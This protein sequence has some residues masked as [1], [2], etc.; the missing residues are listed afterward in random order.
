MALRFSEA[1][2]NSTKAHVETGRTNEKQG[3]MSFL[4]SVKGMFLSTSDK[5]LKFR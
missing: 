5:L 4:S 2:A 1:T 3:L